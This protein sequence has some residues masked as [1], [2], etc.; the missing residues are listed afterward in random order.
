MTSAKKL[1]LVLPLLVATP[2][3]AQERS[4]TGSTESVVR[5]S[6]REPTRQT[7]DRDLNLRAYAELLRK[8]MK[9]Q[10]AAIITEI[11]QF[12]DAE[13]ATFWPLFR[14]YDTELTKVADGRVDIIDDYIQSYNDITDAKAELLMGK[15]FD[16]EAQRAQIKKKHF[17]IMKAALGAKTA[18]RFFQ[19]E[20]QMQHVIDLQIAASLPTMPTM[21]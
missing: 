12:S 6:D 16:L 3:C 9:M 5:A 18:A 7:D 4:T 14:Q 17:N 21:Q 13:A 1:W 11:M 19:V 2:A 20:N 15:A 10:R 8:D